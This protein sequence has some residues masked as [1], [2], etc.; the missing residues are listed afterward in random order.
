MKGDIAK[1][2]R[3]FGSNYYTEASWP[4]LGQTTVDHRLGPCLEHREGVL[5]PESRVIRCEWSGGGEGGE[6]SQDGVTLLLGSS[7]AFVLFLVLTVCNKSRGGAW[8]WG[9]RTM[10]TW[11]GFHMYCDI[12][13]THLIKALE[14][15]REA[16]MHAEN[17][18]LHQC[19]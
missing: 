19:N 1:A 5:S 4:H 15:R 8:K 14:V 3:W 17:G 2:G 11:F 6:R 16:S 13:L 18:V 7:P 12:V 9:Y 10:C